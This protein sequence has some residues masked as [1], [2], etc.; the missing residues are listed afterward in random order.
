MTSHTINKDRQ[1]SLWGLLAAATC[2]GYVEF[3]TQGPAVWTAR[4]LEGL[5]SG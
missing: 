4:G 2:F 5:E 1:Q 3:N